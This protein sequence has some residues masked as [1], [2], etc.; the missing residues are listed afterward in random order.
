MRSFLRR[1]PAGLSLANGRGALDSSRSSKRGETVVTSAGS[2]ASTAYSPRRNTLPGALHASLVEERA[3]LA[4]TD[5]LQDLPGAAEI[6]GFLHPKHLSEA[7]A[8][9]R[10]LVKLRA[11]GDREI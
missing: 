7:V 6:D 4:D 5:G 10:D 1:R 8:D 9:T 2:P 3:L 11:G